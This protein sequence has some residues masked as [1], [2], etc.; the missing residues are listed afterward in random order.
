MEIP[1]KLGEVVM[2]LASLIAS[3]AGILVLLSASGVSA[4]SAAEAPRAGWYVG[5]GIGGPWP[6]NLAQSGWNR[7][8]ICYPTD[9]CFDQDP[10]PDI[11]GYRWHYDIAAATGPVFE[12]STGL[13]VA[14]ARVELSF[15]QRWNDLDQ[16]FL[17]VT[18][19]AG[20]AMADRGN[21]TVTADTRS[22]IDHLAVRML[23]V[24]AYYDFAAGS[25]VSPYLGAG[26]GPAFVTVAGV[27]FSDEYRDTAVNS[28]VYDPPL[29]F[30]NTSLDDDLSDTVL[31]GHLHAGADVRIADRT[32]L[33]L[34]MT[35]SMLDD[36]E[37][38]GGYDLHAAH[39]LDPDFEYHDTF[40]AA[41]SWTL[42]FTGKYAFDN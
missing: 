15:R 13:F 39:A 18:N 40:A 31:A 30:Y 7:D 19:Y 4:Q 36:I 27:R 42:M 12:L 41:R 28:D 22:S 11:S 8:P 9:A 33:G 1:V 24:N 29:S 34:K 21:S 37:T 26:V 20:V 6:S 2:R 5:G 25:V 16:M 23:T 17:S 32:W 38:R 10:R 3:A 35:Y 14:R